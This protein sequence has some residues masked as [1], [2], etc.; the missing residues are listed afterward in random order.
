MTCIRYKWNNVQQNRD[1][2]IRYA[3]MKQITKL[4]RSVDPFIS[5][6]RSQESVLRIKQDRNVARFNLPTE[7]RNLHALEVPE[8]RVDVAVV[9][10]VLWPIADGGRAPLS[11]SNYQIQTFSLRDRH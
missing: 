9:R 11:C 8:L 1:A 5:E 2:F 7:G 3:A 10:A 6:V 4:S